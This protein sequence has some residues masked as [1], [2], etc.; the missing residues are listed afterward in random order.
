MSFST[1]NPVEA[2]PGN[3]SVITLD[4]WQTAALNI[5]QRDSWLLSYIDILTLFLT[6][7]V[8]LLVLEPKDKDAMNKPVE[9]A[10]KIAP[11]PT[12]ELY[13]AVKSELKLSSI[14]SALWPGLE[15]SESDV[16]ISLMMEL[17]E[18]KKTETITFFV[19]EEEPETALPQTAL[20]AEPAPAQ[21]ISLADR[22]MERLAA[23][24]LSERLRAR[25]VDKA[26]QLEVN[27]NIL[28]A[29]A[30]VEMKSEGKRLLDDLGQLF[31]KNEA[32]ITI[33]GH[34]DSRPIS[35]VRFPSNWELSSG[36]AT[37]VARYLIDRGYDPGRLR[38]LG[39]ADTQPL[40]NNETAEGRARNR[41]VSLVVRFK[42]VSLP[43]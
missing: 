24:G 22:M 32:I 43:N 8:V 12:V 28:F 16:D 1:I 27:D 6:L 31:N 17:S 11:P 39:Y 13:S 29:Q 14:P 35:S 2:R 26:V 37:R 15:E 19:E 42:E 4:P 21:E 34:T 5:D 38:A 3:D 23:A 40:A 30:S 20:V 41:R 10:V 25:K 9:E 33:E 7:L 36:R 18:Q